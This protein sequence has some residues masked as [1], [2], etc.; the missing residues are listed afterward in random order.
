M[1][2]FAF[3]RVMA[4]AEA[5]KLVAANRD[6]RF[7]AGGTNLIDLMKESV[8]RPN[9]LVD[10]SRLPLSVV[11]ALPNGG[12]SIGVGK[13][14]DTANHPIFARSSVTEPSYPRRSLT[15]I[16][17][18]ATNGGNLLQRTRCI[19]FTISVLLE[20][21]TPAR[22]G[23]RVDGA[24]SIVIPQYSVGAHRALQFI[25]RHVCA[26]PALD[27]VALVKELTT[28]KEDQVR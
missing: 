19:I 12:V 1:K 2:P 10:I 13:E 24:D 3:K 16:R 18:M 9:E 23:L 21:Q 14:S 27:A 20:K 15:Q 5:V 22:F 25:L 8:D 4:P 17:N 7:I 6:A 26:C 28:R 11:R